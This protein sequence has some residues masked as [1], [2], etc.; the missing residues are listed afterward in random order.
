MLSWWGWSDWRGFFAHPARCA[1]FAAFLVRFV[2]A[3]WRSH[4]N[5]IGKGRDDKRLREPGFF[6]LLY[7]AVL[8]VL[9]SPYFD[10]R[11]LWLLPGGDIVRYTGLLAF[12][13]G[14]VLAHFAQV[15]LGR[16]FSGCITLQE[17]HR[18]VTDGPFAYI[19]HP[20]YAGLILL[21][22][23]LPLVFLSTVGLAA[24]ICCAALFLGRMRREEGFL[25]RE[26]GE[27]WA[28][29]ARRTKRLFPGIY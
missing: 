17:D 26:F 18:L 11:D 8:G 23:G 20:R 13:S 9:A 3:A 5:M 27:Q 22:I 16:F 2:H 4:P 1:L 15:H 7:V 21:F 12:L 6:A 28:A 14:L 29:Y 24:G 10:A 25:A 19:R